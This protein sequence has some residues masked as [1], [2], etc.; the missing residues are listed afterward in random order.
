[1]P[2]HVVIVGSGPAGWTAAIYAGRANLKPLLLEGA[3]SEENRLQGTMPLGQLALTTE[4]ENY[5][6]FPAGNLSEFLRSSLD[7]AAT[8]RP[9]SEQSYRSTPWATGT[10]R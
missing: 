5:P 3:V 7:S 10:I 9:R 4:V 8:T 2:E 6:G 1:M